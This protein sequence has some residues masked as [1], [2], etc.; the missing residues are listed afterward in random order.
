[1][2]FR[3]L[4]IVLALAT[5]C[6]FTVGGQ[7]VAPPSSPVGDG[8]AGNPPPAPVTPDAATPQPILVKDMAMTTPPPPPSD[9]AGTVGWGDPCVNDGDC[10]GH[11]AK[12]LTSAKGVSFLGGYCTTS[13]ANN[14]ACPG[15]TSCAVY[16]DG[17]WCLKS[18]PPSN[19][20]DGYTCCKAQSVCAP[21]N[22]CI[23]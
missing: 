4:G 21:S 13:C 16:D 3:G 8:P 18:C 7:P 2:Q 23:D 1:M 11:G 22:A 20:R 5:G 6:N 10:G 19:C 14:T 12:C 15:G 17:S 9:L